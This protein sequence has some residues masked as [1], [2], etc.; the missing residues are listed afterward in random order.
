MANTDL[1]FG[2]IGYTDRGAWSSSYNSGNGY[3]YLDAVTH[4]SNY[5]ISLDNDNTQTPSD[6]ASKWRKALDGKTATQAAATANTAATNANTKA[7]LANDAA[8]LANTKAG[9]ADS[10]AQA[11]NEA[12]EAA[13][14]AVVVAELPEVATETAVRNI[15]RNYTPTN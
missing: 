15:V 11:A 4:D 12:A 13:A 14:A 7:D 6:S 1:D 9:L 10:A 3:E 5:W 8:T 2:K